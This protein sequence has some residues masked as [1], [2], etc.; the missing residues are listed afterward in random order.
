LRKLLAIGLVWPALACLL[1]PLVVRADAE[2]DAEIRQLQASITALQQ[3][4]QSL[5]QQ[6][7]MTQELRRTETQDL[8]PG[9]TQNSPVYDIYS[10]ATSYED[11][12]R[13]KRERLDRIQKYTQD[14]NSMYTRY[15]ALEDQKGALRARIDELMQQRT[16]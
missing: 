15:R 12:E 16:Q 14:L 8:N 3:E 5:Y 6:F 13:A 7:Q 2:V 4:Q 10:P 9:V 11:Q 1:M